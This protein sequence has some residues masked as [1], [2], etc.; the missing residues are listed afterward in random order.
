VALKYSTTVNNACLNAIEDAIGPSAIMKLRTGPAPANLASA[1]SGTVLATIALPA[2]WMADAAAGSKAKS[3]TWSTTASAGGW[4]GHYRIYAAD[5]VT[6]HIQDLVSQIWTATTAVV[7]GQQMHNGGNV[8]RATTAGTT[9]ASGGPTGTG[10][11]I[12]DGTAAWAFV[13]ALGLTLDNTNIVAGQ[14]FLIAS[15]ALNAANT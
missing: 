15:Y 14:E 10:T 1:D 4:G 12:A 9:A 8:Y 2:N 5:G 3:G 6:P 13:G 11:G 7:V